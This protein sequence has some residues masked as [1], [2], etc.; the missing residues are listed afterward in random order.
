MTTEPTRLADEGFLSDEVSAVVSAIRNR[1]PAHFR[2]INALNRLL[3][4]AQYRLHVHQESARELTCAALFVRSLAH[5]QA[6]VILLE[7]GM[8]PSARALVRCALEGLFNLG[9]CAADWKTALAFVDADQIDR[10]RKARYLRQVQDP[11]AKATLEQSDLDEIL[12]QIDNKIE[13]VEAREVRTRKMAKL[14]G[15]EDMYLT[16]YAQ[17]SGAVHSTVGDLDQ[18][19]RLDASGQRL[20]MLTE[21]TVDNLDGVLLMLGE[22]M[23]GLARA[24]KKVFD[25]VAFEECEGHLVAFQ[26]LYSKTG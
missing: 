8:Q 13:E 19:F 11:D 16:A 18:H 9:A 21:P 24:A 5:C 26:K 10:K 23:V 15:L 17:L 4:V 7:R 14:A 2:E 6:S 20:E 12:R 22:T 25:L 1:Y 3:T